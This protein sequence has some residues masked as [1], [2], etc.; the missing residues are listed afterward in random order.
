MSAPHNN[1]VAPQDLALDDLTRRVREAHAGGISAFADA[2]EKAIAAG[3]ALKEADKLISHGQK[4]GFYKRCGLGDRQA[5]RYKKLATLAAANPTY[6]SDLAG[7]T[8][9][10]AIKKL[11]PPKPKATPRHGMILSGCRIAVLAARS[12]ACQKCVVY[13]CARRHA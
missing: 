13:G 3:Q 7:L 2:I 1:R 10:S 4:A 9:E 12:S 6:K 8:V 11:S 5:E